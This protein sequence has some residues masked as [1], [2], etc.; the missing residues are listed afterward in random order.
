MSYSAVFFGSI[1]TIADTSELQRRAYNLAFRQLDLDWVWDA[2]SY[3]RMLEKPGGRDRVAKYAE[4]AGDTVDAEQVH[5][6]K[7]AF[8]KTLAQQN[9]LTPR[10]GVVDLI[11]EARARGLPVAFCTTTD[12]AQVDLVL[13]AC[14][15]VSNADFMWVGDRTLTKNGKPASDIYRIAFEALHLRPEQVLAI[16]DTP[17]S[18]LAAIGAG[19]D[20]IGFPGRAAMGRDFP[21]GTNEV[22]DELHEGLLEANHQS[23]NIAAE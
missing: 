22:V 19:I 23:R 5:A 1:G 3:Y 20:T 17:E 8:F 11:A 9:G 6:L 16:E 12:R 21:R 15:G 14:E 2:N 4:A 18:A 10:P 13:N 7:V